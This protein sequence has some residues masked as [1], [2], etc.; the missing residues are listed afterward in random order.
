M[1]D[2]KMIRADPEKVRRALISRGEDT[3]QL[4][5]F[6]A[7][8]D[9]RR[10]L[11]TKTESLKAERNR[12]SE[13][14][15]RMKRASADASAEIDRMRGVGEQI[16]E[17]DAQVSKVESQV[18]DILLRMPNVPSDTTPVGKDA[19]DNRIVRTWAIRAS[20]I[21]SLRRTGTSP[22]RSTS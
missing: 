10:K 19:S 12:A 22:P 2:A 21:S 7:L 14:I 9:D 13:D 3:A 20:S 5:R 17:L 8:D 16:K 6:L 4:D 11:L 18:E 15:A 1:L